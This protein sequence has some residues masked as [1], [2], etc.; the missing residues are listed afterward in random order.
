MIVI[1]L[2]GVLAGLL[3]DRMGMHRRRRLRACGG[4]VLRGRRLLLGG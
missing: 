3:A 2:L 4:A 1:C